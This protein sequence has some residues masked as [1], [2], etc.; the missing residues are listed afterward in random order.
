MSRD[1]L[2]D[3]DMYKQLT[4]HAGWSEKQMQDHIV[5]N[6]NEFVRDVLDDHYIDHKVEWGIDQQ[7]RMSPRGRRVDLIIKGKLYTYYCE[8][9]SPQSLTENRFGIGQL[10]DY[11]REFSDPQKRLLL[12]TSKFDINT[13]LTIDHYKLPITYIYLAKHGALVYKKAVLRHG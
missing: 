1:V 3:N 7:L 11:G 5:A 12:I 6:I 4:N 13:A 9:K 2:V 8:L 10:L